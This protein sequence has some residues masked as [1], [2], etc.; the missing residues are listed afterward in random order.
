M[1][2]LAGAKMSVGVNNSR[3][4]CLFIF[5]WH[6]LGIALHALSGRTHSPWNMNPENGFTPA[7]IAA[8]RIRECPARG[9]GMS[10][11]SVA[12]TTASSKIVSMMRTQHSDSCCCGAATMT[13]CPRVC[14]VKPGSPNVSMADPRSRTM[15]LHGH[16]ECGTGE[17]SRESH[18]R[19]PMCTSISRQVHQPGFKPRPWF[20]ANG[21]LMRWVGPWAAILLGLHVAVRVAVRHCCSGSQAALARVGD[22]V[23]RH[24]PVPRRACALWTAVPPGIF[25][26]FQGVRREIIA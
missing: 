20:E 21:R 6:A 13:H 22:H 14:T 5:Q 18:S 23:E 7:I 16:A 3:T 19:S 26:M 2:S 11:T 4:T 24:G 10:A 17:G 25:Y 8:S 9:R 15:F 12:P 1:S